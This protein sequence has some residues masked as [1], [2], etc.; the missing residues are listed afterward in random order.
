MIPQDENYNPKV[1][2]KNRKGKKSVAW[3]SLGIGILT[4]F[5]A[6]STTLNQLQISSAESKIQ[7]YTVWLRDINQAMMDMRG[8]VFKIKTQRIRGINAQV[9]RY[10]HVMEVASAYTGADGIVGNLVTK[11]ASLLNQFDESV[12]DLLSKTS[13]PDSAWRYYLIR[14]SLIIS[15]KT[16]SQLNIINEA[17]KSSISRITFNFKDI[18]IVIKNKIFSLSKD[19][20][21]H[22]N[23]KQ[24]MVYPE[25]VTTTNHSCFLPSQHKTNNFS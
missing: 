24:P 11:N 19:K 5:L 18:L 3:L 14:N 10:N 4:A 21:Y 12:E 17:Q 6:A 23:I 8:T 13:P 22:F 1:Q 25:S 7:Q 9:M 15:L 16:K 2:D 20:S